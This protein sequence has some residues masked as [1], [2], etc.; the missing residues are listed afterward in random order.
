MSRTSVLILGL[1]VA[2]GCTSVVDARELAAQRSCRYEERCGNIGAGKGYAGISECLTD[3]RAD[4]LSAWPTDRCD[5]RV[6]PETLNVCL[7]AIDNTRCND[8]V[9][10]LNT[11]LKCGSDDVCSKPASGGSGCNCGQGQTCCNN[12]CV[13]LSQDRNNCGACGTQ[14]GPSTTCQSG[15]CK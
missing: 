5:G 4:F 13:V 15:A 12:S 8:F 14:C 7:T 2:S 1:L 10:A 3:K 11:A 9:D 6:N